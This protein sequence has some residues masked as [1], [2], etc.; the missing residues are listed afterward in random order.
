MNSGLGPGLVFQVFQ[1][2]CGTVDGCLN[3]HHQ[4]LVPT[5]LGLSH[6]DSVEGPSASGR[7]PSGMG[8]LPVSSWAADP[9]G[10]L[11]GPSHVASREEGTVLVVLSFIFTIIFK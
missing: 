3:H 6:V 4:T 1:T 11:G 8:D 7:L 9:C 5:M 10:S 2:L